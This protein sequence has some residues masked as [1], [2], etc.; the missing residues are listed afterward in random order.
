MKNQ[1]QLLF[2][3]L[4]LGLFQACSQ[5]E[6]TSD[7]LTN[8]F[9][10]KEGFDIQAIAA[11]PLLNSPVAMTFDEKGR[12]WAVELPGYMR[13]IE[14]QDEEAPD[15]KIVILTDE[16]GDGVIDNRQVFMDSLV[17]PRTLLHAYGGLLYSN[18]IGLWWAKLDDTKM[19][20][21]ELVDSL[22]VVGGNI[23]HQPNGLL[24]NIDNWIYS[25]KCKVRYRLK[26]GK[27]L[28][29][30]TSFRGQWG[31]SADVNGRLYY[32]NN[33]TAIVT[34]RTMPN[35][36]LQNSYQKTRFGTNQNIA[37]NKKLYGYQ[38]T[39]V[40]RGYQEGV[41]DSTGKITS[42]TS[43]C[44][45][46]VYTG[47]LL[48]ED[49]FQN[50]FVCA[51]EANA[52]KR[53]I[54]EEKDGLKTAV[55]AYEDSEFLVSKDE[56]FRPINLYNAPDGSMY[57]LDLRKGVI[58]HRAYMT[59][60]LREKILAKGLDT[61]NGK[62]RIY[63]IVATEN[64]SKQGQNYANLEA[65]ELVEMLAAALP[66]QRNF[67]QQQLIFRQAKSAKA[68]IEKMALNAENP[69]GQLHAI[70]TLEGL[71][72]LDQALWTQLTEI[73]TD[74][75]VHETLIRLSA[76][77]EEEAKQFVYFQKMVAL[78]DP[79]INRQLAIRLGQ[80][81]EA[82]ADSL[83]L[84]LVKTNLNDG[85][86]NE[87]ILSGIGGKEA[88]LMKQLN[89]LSD[90]GDLMESLQVVMNNQ[91]ENKI[92]TPQL[93]TETKLDARTQGYALYSK[94][95]ASCHGVDGVGNENL[96]PPLMDSEYVS[97]SKDRLIALVLNGMQGPLTV[98]G[99]VYNIKT[100]MPGI[101]NNPNLTDKDIS[102]LLV[103]LRNSFSLSDTNIKE[104]D[105]ATWRAKTKARM[106]LFTEEELKD[107]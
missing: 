100:P 1:N 87:A 105:V 47:N 72:A 65:S 13:D 32:N 10:L 21:K 107:Y 93:P 74:S 44:S 80:M 66:Y 42:L 84:E 82:T 38:A 63:R 31:I 98:Q 26:D 52:I 36:L 94:F 71:N 106:T 77:F 23:E 6:S 19:V 41:L 102:D 61:L 59:N 5:T 15:G 68:A 54:L 104:K 73:T 55:P 27:W 96:A 9:I 95:C 39:S 62:G 17:A 3:I 46:L 14:G 24:Y 51:P 81:K 58:Q 28:R 69:Y 35:Q 53:Y 43:A 92:Q 48:G 33:S 20:R 18:G 11:E 101:K 12:I 16:D 99:K 60:Y 91:K 85:L 49:F 78:N 97:G 29:E 25:A 34:D 45:P 88:D 40:N 67:A 64:K 83:L 86:L 103:F 37:A 22:Y 56:T 2:F 4:L 76:T 50:T 75:M 57:V 89:T 79:Y 7:F 90:A 30:P 70:W 8:E